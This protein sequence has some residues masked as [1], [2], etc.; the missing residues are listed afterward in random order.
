M[1]SLLTL[2][3][4]TTL[5][6]CASMGS[7][8]PLAFQPYEMDAEARTALFEA[9]AELEGD[10]STE[11]G[12]ISRFEITSNG[13]VIKETLFPGQPHEMTNMYTLDGNGLAMTHY[14]SMGNQPHMRA[15]AIDGNKIVFSPTGVS[16]R[17]SADELFMA[18]MTLTKID[19]HT[20]DIEWTS[21]QGNQPGEVMTFHHKRID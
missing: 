7:K 4:L 16:D 18:S 5:A 2:G 8:D 9:V 20:L 15:T 12:S 21:Y 6:S 3:F 14:C 1:Q 11:D 17:G 10:W 19:E 13:T